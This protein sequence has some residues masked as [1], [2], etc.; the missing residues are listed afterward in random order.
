M[1]SAVQHEP[2]A[3]AKQRSVAEPLKKR[4]TTVLFWATGPHVIVEFK[5]IKDGFTPEQI[6]PEGLTEAD[7]YSRPG[8]DGER[9]R[10]Q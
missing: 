2:G 6:E 3:R 8:P 7:P 1:A 10:A 5:K 4:I 9:A